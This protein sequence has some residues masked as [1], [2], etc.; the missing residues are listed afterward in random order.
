[1]IRWTVQIVKF[2]I[3]QGICVCSSITSFLGPY[4]LIFVLKHFIF[5]TLISVLICERGGDRFLHES[6]VDL[7]SFST[8]TAVIVY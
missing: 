4:F 6:V 7:N 8:E 2:G 3:L 1:M 5:F